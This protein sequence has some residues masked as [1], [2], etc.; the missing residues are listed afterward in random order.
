M[1]NVT[2]IR[3][4]RK[5]GEVALFFRY[6]PAVVTRDGK[7]IEYEDLKISIYANPKNEAQARFNERIES[8]VE[9]I[10]LRRAF[11]IME[12]RFEL[13]NPERNKKDFLE[14][15]RHQAAAI[16][17]KAY[18]SFLHLERFTSGRCRF[19]N[20]T[21]ELCEGF[22]QFLLKSIN[23][24][25]GRP[26]SQNT[27]S[28]YYSTFISILKTAY[29]MKHL[30]EDITLSLTNIRWDRTKR[31]EYLNEDEIEM[32]SAVDFKHKD[33]QRAALL[34]CETGLRRSDIIDLR[35]KHIIQRGDSWYIEKVMVKTGE[36]VCIPLTQKARQLIGSISQ[37][38]YVFPSLT[39]CRIN[40]FLPELI[41]ASGTAKHITFHSFRHTYAQ[42]LSLK[43][44]DI[45]AISNVLGHKNIS[46]TM[47]YAGLRKDM[48]CSI[49][50]SLM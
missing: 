3:Q 4:K 21:I 35:G 16:S 34:S 39:I 22:K 20:I 28:A 13:Y 49:I 41:K 17:D 40:R 15:Y 43:G 10:R 12:N 32:L 1:Y 27:A 42:R 50:E 38:A 30:P 7:K 11:E 23:P 37:D 47:I 36:Q 18:S 46:T 8:M 6:C 29:R 44:I 2:L 14:F 48:V 19:Y 33:I 24:R 45:R 5:G 9:D 25:T 26:L 31:K